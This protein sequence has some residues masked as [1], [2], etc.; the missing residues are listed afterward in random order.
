M[1]IITAP[2]IKYLWSGERVPGRKCSYVWNIVSFAD[3]YLSLLLY[4]TLCIE[5]DFAFD[6]LGLGKMTVDMERYKVSELKNGR[7]AMLAFSG[8]VTQA[9]LYDKGF[10]CKLFFW[11]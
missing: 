7:L 5:G 8:I 2:T 1:E 9:A 6:P 4:L 3:F 11:R 10:P